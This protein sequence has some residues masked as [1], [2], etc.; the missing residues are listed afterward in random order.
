MRELILISLLL[1]ACF[2]GMKVLQQ[3]PGTVTV[4]SNGGPDTS[5]SEED[6]PEPVGAETRQG[7][8]PPYQ[9]H[10]Q[11]YQP[12][13]VS[14]CNC[15][16]VIV[17]KKQHICY[18][19]KSV[20][21]VLRQPAKCSISHTEE[22]SGSAPVPKFEMYK[23]V[24]EGAESQVVPFAMGEPVDGATLFKG[25][26]VEIDETIINYSAHARLADLQRKNTQLHG[27]YHGVPFM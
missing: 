27:Y 16:Y 22:Y 4:G 5:D 17:E 13:P 14:N 24:H 8:Q 3:R 20:L 19:G 25:D 11:R 9:Q 1:P 18:P 21:K 6:E 10:Y 26:S 23:N 15:G 12:E 7:Y 2:G